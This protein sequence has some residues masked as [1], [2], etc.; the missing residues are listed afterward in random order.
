MPVAVGVEEHGPE[1]FRHPVLREQGLV[2]AHEPAV[3]LLDEELPGLILRAAEERV[4]QS[5]AVHVGYRHE[6]PLGR[7]QLGNQALAIEVHELVLAMHVGEPEAVRDVGEERRPTVGQSDGR[8]ADPM[9]IRLSNGHSLVRRDAHQ[10]AP[11][12]VRPLDSDRVD[13]VALTDPEAEHVVDARLEPAGRLLFL[14]EL[15]AAAPKRHLRPDG[16]AV[17]A[18]ALEPDLEIMVPGERAGVVAIDKGFLID[19]VDDQVEGAVAVEV[20]VGGAAGEARRVEPPGRAPVGEG[21]VAVV[22]ERVVRQRSGGHRGDEPQEIHPRAP[23]GR[24]HRLVVRQEGDVVLRRDVLGEP[25]RHVDVLVAVE[26]EIGDERAPGPVRPGHAGELP[27]VGERAVAVVEL[28]HVAHELVVVPV[29]QLGLIDVPALERRRRLQ[30]VFV[31]GEHV[32][33]VDVRPAVVVHVRDVEPHR[34]IARVGH[35]AR[36]RFGKGAVAVVEV[37]VVVLEEVVR[38]VKVGPAVAVHVAHSDP[39]A[40]ADLAPVDARGRAHVGEVPAVVAIQFRAAEGVPLVARV[41]L[42]EARDRPGRI[43]D[44]EQVQVPV[45]VVV[46]EDGLGRIARVRD[47]VRRRLLDEGRDAVGVQPLV[48]VQL[49]GPEFALDFAGV[50]DVEVEPAV[51]VHVGESDAGGPALAVQAGFRGDVAE[52]ELPLVQVQPGA[53]EIR[54]E[55]DFGEP[56]AA[57]VPQRHPAAVVEVAVGEDV[58]LG[59]GGE[60]ILE[61]DAGVAGGQQRE[62]SAS[63]RGRLTRERRTVPPR[64]PGEQVSP[65]HQEPTCLLPEAT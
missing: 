3:G 52:A 20:A 14:E 9:S 12:S 63:G 24:A 60:A 15:L 2:G 10:D 26:I 29:P 41:L 8:T 62:Q 17:A 47:A 11:A 51:A 34:E 4:V 38:H 35:R 23:R 18:L 61:V 55:H 49:V 65:G 53:A 13:R 30:P 1:V 46:E 33:R 58:Q 59:G 43:V 50:A 36:D 45:A 6:R 27:D 7:D 44:D 56:V 19:G 28:E 57:H 48:D 64:A 37:E 5:V 32:G 39:Q 40:E 31:L 16:E 22:L 54:G 21:P 42:P 25:V